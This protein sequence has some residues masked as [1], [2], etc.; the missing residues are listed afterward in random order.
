MDI[1]QIHKV[2]NCLIS[3]TYGNTSV[4]KTGSVIVPIDNQRYKV[5]FEKVSEEFA[6]NEWIPLNVVKIDK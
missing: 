5:F 4:P 6:P 3:E 2:A 1:P